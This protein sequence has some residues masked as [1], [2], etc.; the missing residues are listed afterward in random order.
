VTVAAAPIE[1]VLPRP[2]TRRGLL[3]WNAILRMRRD[4]L[5]LQDVLGCA[6]AARRGV[7]LLDELESS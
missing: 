1:N 6:R 5:E 2:K 4:V 3:V 7:D